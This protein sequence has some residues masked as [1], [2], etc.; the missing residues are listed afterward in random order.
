MKKGRED[1]EERESKDGK[2]EKL[3]APCLPPLNCA[4]SEELLTFQIELSKE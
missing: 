3:D 2:K 4:N 1:K